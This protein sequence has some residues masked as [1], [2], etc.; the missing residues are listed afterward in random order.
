M[1]NIFGNRKLEII[2]N[3]DNE[4]CEKIK[5]KYINDQYNDFLKNEYNKCFNKI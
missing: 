2:D 5:E 1:D 3:N 4:Y